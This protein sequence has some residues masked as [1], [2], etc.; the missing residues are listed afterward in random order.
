MLEERSLRSLNATLLSTAD[1][2]LP[3]LYSSLRSCRCRF[4][5][6]H[7]AMSLRQK[8][9][10]LESQLRCHMPCYDSHAAFCRSSSKSTLTWHLGLLPHVVAR[11]TKSIPRPERYWP[12]RRTP[13]LSVASKLESGEKISWFKLPFSVQIKTMKEGGHPFFV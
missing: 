8:C 7:F 12:M 13:K 1:I 11:Y 10:E 3:W 2:H 4:T 9:S 6:G 5:H